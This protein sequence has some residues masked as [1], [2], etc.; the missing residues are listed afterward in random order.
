MEDRTAQPSLLPNMGETDL[1]TKYEDVYVEHVPRDDIAEFIY[2]GD[3][4]QEHDAT[5]RAK[6]KETSTY[7]FKIPE[8]I[9]KN[10]EAID[11]A[12]AHVKI[13]DP[14]IGSGA[15]P[16]G[17]MNEIVRARQM[18]NAYLGDEGRTPYDFKR[19][20]IQESI[21]GVD[22]E[23]SAVDIA[24]LR[25]WLSLVVDEDDFGN[26]K[27][28]P[29]LDYKIVVGNSLIGFP[30]GTQGRE[31]KLR[32]LTPL[33]KEYLSTYS[34][35]GKDELK[36]Q[37]N[38]I[39]Q[40]EYN[41]PSTELSLGYKVDFDFRWSFFEIFDNNAGFDIIIA[42]PPYISH[43]KIQGKK[44]IKQQFESFDAFA[45]IYC[46]FIELAI[47]IQSRK[48]ALCFITSNSYLRADYGRRI[49]N[50]ICN[51]QK[52]RNIANLEKSQIFDSAIVNTAILISCSNATKSNNAKIVVKNYDGR[53][54]FNNFIALNGFSYEQKDFS[55]Q[56]WTLVSREYLKI[57]KRLDANG[58]S[59]EKRGAKIRLGIATGANKAFL[60]N[61]EKKNQLINIDIKNSEI[62]KPVLRGRDINRYSYHNPSSYI[63]LTRNEIEVQKEYP[64]IF[65]YLGTF[66]DEFKERGAK[67]KHW[68]NLRACAFFDDFKKNKIIWIELT[69]KSKFSLF[70]RECP[71]FCV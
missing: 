22:I 62:I 10:A 41:N 66:G 59:L 52:I 65:E 57:K 49:R 23:P 36:T 46:Y 5:T 25:L 34:T 15:F 14:A 6:D 55:G 39:I 63:V 20:A 31:E 30:F 33:K 8:T 17:V 47:N 26:I 44:P 53:T 32:K 42:N 70:A 13:C 2:H 40:S 1:L 27:P 61:E 71:S 45:D 29:N 51:Q 3:V 19:N 7:S 28:L 4:A 56:P 12:L 21:Y 43:D 69:D 67:G 60:L 54:T 48:G 58:V 64:S 35:M 38:G 68:S 16:V 24:K 18:L 37:I 9:R 50:L 11:E